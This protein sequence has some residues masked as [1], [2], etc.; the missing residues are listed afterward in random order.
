MDFVRSGMQ[1]AKPRFQKN[2]LMTDS[3]TMAVPRVGDEHNAYWRSAIDNAD[4]KLI[5]A[6]PEMLEALIFQTKVFENVVLRGQKFEVC[7]F[8]KL[9]E[10]YVKNIDAIGKA[11]GKSWEEIKELINEN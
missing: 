6:T 1:G 5:E 10:A 9:N 2:H 11:T 8:E 7:H 3:I 4:A